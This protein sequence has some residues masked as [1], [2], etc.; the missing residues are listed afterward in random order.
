MQN[1]KMQCRRCR[2]EMKLVKGKFH[3]FNLVG[4][5]CRACKEIVYDAKEIQPILEYNKLM[6]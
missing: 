4:W 3:G 2:A 5:K 1:M 6:G